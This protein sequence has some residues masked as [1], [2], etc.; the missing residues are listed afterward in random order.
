MGRAATRR[1]TSAG[2]VVFR[3]EGTGVRYLLILDRNGSWGFPKGHLDE[4]E[5]PLDAARRE[6]EEETGLVD[7]V[8]RGELGV[9]DWYFRV[10]G[11]LVHKHCHLYLFESTQGEV[12]PQLEEGITSCTWYELD[13]ALRSMPY[14]NSRAVLKVAGSMV[15]SMPP[16]RAAT[17]ES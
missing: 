10:R 16:V 17:G 14:E 9:I 2:G 8:L 7:V 5:A 1:E 13:E 15:A 6:V 3:R 11:D 4:G 12:T